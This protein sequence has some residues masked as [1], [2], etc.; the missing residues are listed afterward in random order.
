MIQ[1]IMKAGISSFIATLSFA[2]LFNVK[3]DKLIYAGIAGAV[4]GILYKLGVVYFGWGEYISNFVGAI[5]LA[6]VSE[7]FARYKRTPISTFLVCALIPLV[8]G[9]NL[10]RMIVMIMDNKLTLAI[11]YGVM[12]VAIALVLAI[13][14]LLVS[15]CFQLYSKAKK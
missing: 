7:V 4:G 15:T 12:T 9:G 2:I 11:S 3:K 1:I 14:I 6:F 13:G 8:P 5:G 10:F